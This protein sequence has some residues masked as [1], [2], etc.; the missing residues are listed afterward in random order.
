V[1]RIIN[2]T[3]EGELSAI[4]TA[5]VFLVDLAYGVSTTEKFITSDLFAVSGYGSGADIINLSDNE[6]EIRLPGTAARVQEVIDGDMRDGT[7]TITAISDDNDYQTVVMDGAIDS[8]RYTGGDIILSVLTETLL[9]KYTPVYTYNS[10]ANFMPA[11]GEVM[12]WDGSN[13]IAARA[14]ARD[15][16]RQALLERYYERHGPTYWYSSLGVATRNSGVQFSQGSQ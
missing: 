12:D 15:A 10:F 2:P 7:C 8:V 1:P 14:A 9:G 13:V 11:E 16:Q 5:P 4:V 3:F 6:A